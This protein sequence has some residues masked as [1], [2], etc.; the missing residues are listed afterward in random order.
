MDQLEGHIQINE[1]ALF[2]PIHGELCETHKKCR[3]LTEKMSQ[4][5][6]K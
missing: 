2:V 5:I 4:I 6:E 3:D 1:Y